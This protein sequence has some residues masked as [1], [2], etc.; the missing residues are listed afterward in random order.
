MTSEAET[1]KDSKETEAK[2]E[3]WVAVKGT[4]GSDNDAS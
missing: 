4:S 2:K 1:D 3:K